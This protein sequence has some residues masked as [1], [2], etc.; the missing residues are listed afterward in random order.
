MLD[1]SVINWSV[2]HAMQISMVVFTTIN[3]LLI[4]KTCN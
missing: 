4:K 2:L 1:Y 3:V